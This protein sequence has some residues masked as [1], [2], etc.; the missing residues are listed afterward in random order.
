MYLKENAEMKKFFVEFSFMI[1][2]KQ[3]NHVKLIT[4]HLFIQTYY[5][6]S[7]FVEYLETFANNNKGSS[8]EY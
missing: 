5:G 8:N 3:I 7:I 1:F 6:S 2:I 4:L